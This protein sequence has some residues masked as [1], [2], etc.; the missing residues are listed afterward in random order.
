MALL[1][2]NFQ[3][4]NWLQKKCQS[5]SSMSQKNIF[6]IIFRISWNQPS[7]I[8]T[9]TR[10]TQ[11]LTLQSFNKQFHM[12]TPTPSIKSHRIFCGTQNSVHCSKCQDILKEQLHQFQWK[13]KVAESHSTS[14]IKPCVMRLRLLQIAQEDGNQS[15]AKLPLRPNW[16][17]WNNWCKIGYELRL[18]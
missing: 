3:H 1:Y 12:Q 7:P 8:I 6:I 18:W 10:F 5:F 13:T 14:S 15:M 17:R 4:F 2:S 9:K 16:Q 11:R